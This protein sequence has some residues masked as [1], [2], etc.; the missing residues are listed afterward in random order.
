MLSTAR[1]DL[2]TV[3]AAEAD[4]PLA[5]RK[6]ECVAGSA[7]HCVERLHAYPQR[8]G[9]LLRYTAAWRF[10]TGAALLRCSSR[11]QTDVSTQDLTVT[12]VDTG[13]VC[14]GAPTPFPVPFSAPDMTQ[15]MSSMLFNNIW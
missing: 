5:A 2:C 11:A 4:G 12:A 9:Q 10:D 15:G 6:S 13:L 7:E 14:L 8:V 3:P 1:G